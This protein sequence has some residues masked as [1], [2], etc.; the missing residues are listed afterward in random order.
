MASDRHMRTVRWLLIVLIVVVAALLRSAYNANTLIVDPIRADA[1]YNLVY[2]N[3]LLDDATFSK[4]MSD[5]PVPDSYWAPGYPIFLAAVIWTSELLSVDTYH[6]ILFCQMLLGVGT[7]ILCFAV[8]ASFL[9]GLWPLLPAILAALSPHLVST[10]SYVLTET[11]FGFLLMLAF[12]GLVRALRGESR[13]S[14]FWAGTYFALAYLVNPVSLFLAPI[15]AVAILLFARS[16]QL[17][18]PLG[19][20][21]RCLVLLLAPLLVTS[22]L[23]SIRSAVVVPADQETASK[24]LLTNLVIGMY[25]DYHEKWRAS[26]L[27]P[28]KKIVAPGAGVDESYGT[29]FEVLV[30]RFKQNPVQMLAWYVVQKPMLLWDWD[31]RTGFGDIYIYRVEYSLY[32][33]SIPAIVTYSFMSALH[34]VVL[35]VSIV[36]LGFLYRRDSKN[37]LLPILLYIALVYVSL[38]YVL[39]Q[40]EPRYSIPLRSEIYICFTFAIWQVSSWLG[41]KKL[42]QQE[43]KIEN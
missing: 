38:I 31:I 39:S 32:H 34:P 42:Q 17:L 36:G 20:V 22:A 12:Y 14:W 18:P 28:E 25:P 15:I 27:E 10:A 2:A 33:T 7:V 23:W 4:D 1:A 41:R 21:Y 43:K 30:Q 29:F 5:S 35:A 11:L 24:R 16:G 3:N 19:K 6:A 8:A 40:S 26:I 13:S 9:P 37:S